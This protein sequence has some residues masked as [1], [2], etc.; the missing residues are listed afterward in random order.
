MAGATLKQLLQDGMAARRRGDR[1]AA[2][3][4]FRAAVA[5]NPSHPGAQLELATELLHLGQ[6]EQAAALCRAV[7]HERPSEARAHLRLGEALRKLGD[8]A[9]ATAAF[10][11]ALAHDPANIPARLELAGELMQADRLPEAEALCRAV[12]AVVPGHA[13]A[14]QRLGQL[15]RKAGNPEAALAAFQAAAAAEPQRLTARLA[16]ATELLELARAAEARETVRGVLADAPDEIDGWLKLGQIE[17]M[18]GQHEAG[19]EAYAE[20]HRRH[21]NAVEPLVGLAECWQALGHPDTAE[22]YLRQ[23]LELRPSHGP[24]LLLLAEQALLAENPEAALPLCRAAAAAL[25]NPLPARIAEGRAIAMLEGPVAALQLLDSAAL[26]LG[27]RAELRVVRAQLLRQLGRVEE[28]RTLLHGVPAG[29][30]DNPTLRT[31]RA[32]LDIELGDLDS[33]AA[34]L[35]R[36]AASR[37]RGEA[38]LATARAALAEARWELGDAWT[39][40]ETA[41]RLDPERAAPHLDLAR[42]ALLLSDAGAAASHLRDWMRRSA[43]G[44]LLRGQSLHISQTKLGQLL[45]EQ[46]LDVGGLAATAALIALPPAERIAPALAGV[47]ERPDYTPA[48]AALLLALR[49]AGILP[50]AGPGGGPDPSV[51]RQIAQFWADPSPPPDVAALMASWP[52]QHPGWGYRRFDDAAALAF[53]RERASEAVIEAY[54]RGQPIAQKADVFRLAWLYFEGG[55]YADADDLC[56]APISEVLAPDTRF[57]AYLEPYA[58]LGNNVLLAAPRDPVIATA[59]SGAVTAVLRGDADMLW[60]ATGPGMITRAFGAELAESDEP[61]ELW[62]RGRIVLEREKMSRSVWPHC[63]VAYKRTDQHWL[64]SAFGGRDPTR[65]RAAI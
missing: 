21:P 30:R 2:E 22:R 50:G 37:A 40:Y 18:V 51:P 48:S 36:G 52:A 29:Q 27:D 34:E 10:Q 31:H 65:A 42:L 44:R 38:S 12:L 47:R 45:D 16:A 59:L 32:L 26:T 24:A 61:P 28:A 35:G 43:P 62:L 15:A 33:A 6:P 14:Q 13:G 53:L 63:A 64:R 23:A 55:L 46:R 1:A 56:R 7:V 58:T 5:L 54:V 57:A 20:A 19:R 17:R 41:L 9:G 60:L 3:A 4:A 25:P 49:Q 11:A 8:R 39:E